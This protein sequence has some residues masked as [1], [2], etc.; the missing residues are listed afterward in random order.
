MSLSCYSPAPVITRK[1]VEKPAPVKPAPPKRAAS[2]SELSASTTRDVS[3]TNGPAVVE[4]AGSDGEQPKEIT[5][6]DVPIPKDDMKG[7]SIC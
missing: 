7:M 3:Q 5:Q 1:S 4:P 6:S 2:R